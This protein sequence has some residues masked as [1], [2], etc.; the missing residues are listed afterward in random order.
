[1]D[2]LTYQIRINDSGHLGNIVTEAHQLD[3]TDKLPVLQKGSKGAAWGQELIEIR[4]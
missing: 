4:C 2:R 1:M 3:L